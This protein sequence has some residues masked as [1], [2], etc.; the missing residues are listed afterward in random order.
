MS[1]QPYIAYYLPLLASLED[2]RYWD[3]LIKSENCQSRELFIKSCMLNFD[4]KAFITLNKYNP[5]Y[6]SELIATIEEH[7]SKAKSLANFVK[8]LQLYSESMDQ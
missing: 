2:L 6:I 7:S 3:V 5:G 1:N 8:K 4:E